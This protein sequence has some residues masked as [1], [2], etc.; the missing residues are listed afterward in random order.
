[1]KKLIFIFI[2]FALI[3]ILFFVFK[4]FLNSKNEVVIEKQKM[5]TSS[6][7]ETPEPSFVPSP[8]SIVTLIPTKTV[9]VTPTP[10]IKITAIPTPTISKTP[11][12]NKSPKADILTASL[13]QTFTTNDFAT[14]QVRATDDYAIQKVEVYINSSLKASITPNSFGGK[15]ASGVDTDKQEEAT[16]KISDYLKDEK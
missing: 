9:K 15:D 12:D 4:T 7:I 2:I 1:M 14:L 5:N 11:S 8:V 3:S 13:N 10:T 16:K 6:L